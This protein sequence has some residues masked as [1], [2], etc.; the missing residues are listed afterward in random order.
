MNSPV[1]IIILNFNGKDFLQPCIASVL[2]QE[3]QGYEILFIDNASNDGSAA[4]VQEK[5]PSVKVISLEKNLGFAGGNNFGVRHAQYD[6]IVLL[7]NDTTVEKNWLENLVNAVRPSDVAVA[8]SLIFT[9]GIPQKYYER[10]G[11]IN[12][13]G[14]NIMRIFHKKEDIF[15][16]GGAS[17]IYKRDILGIPFDDD[18]FAYGEDVYLSLKARFAGY[19]VVHANDSVV[20]HYGSGTSRNQKSSIK[21]FYQER[22]RLLNT[23]LFFSPKTIVK[24]FPLF[25][26]NVLVKKA[27]GFLPTKY[28]ITGIV[29]AYWWLLSNIGLIRKKRREIAT[30]KKVSEED[31][32]SRMTCKVTNGETTAG[33]IMN[34]IALLYFKIV[35]IRTI[36][37]SS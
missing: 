19:R 12:F 30:L 16:A 15:F 29:L 2:K 34:T 14:H 27:A 33:R 18:Y 28:S 22:N 17:L 10:N 31:I 25:A 24:L 36:E 8:S 13:L 1:S 6:L 26:L 7:N 20:H 37:F 3:Y 35:N 21:T 9:D 4:F 23:L 32:I 11:S 5:F